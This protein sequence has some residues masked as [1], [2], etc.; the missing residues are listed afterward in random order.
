MKLIAVFMLVTMLAACAGPRPAAP[1]AATVIAPP[2]WRQGME[3]GGEI[4][5]R[6]WEDF[7][8]PTLSA[9]VEKACA[10][11]IDIALAAARVEEAH[12]QFNAAR[13]QRLPHADLL[14]A[15]RRE[16]FLGAMGRHESQTAAQSEIGLTYDLDLFG[17]LRH[18]SESARARLLAT[19][20]AQDN[21]TLAVASFVAAGYIGLRALDARLDIVR[22]TLIARA[23]SLKIAQR[24]AQ[25]GYATQLEL[26]QAEAEFHAT[27]QL[28]PALQFAITRQENGLSVLLGESPRE[29]A[30]GAP[31]SALTPPVVPTI[32]PSEL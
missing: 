10:N 24:R 15:G 4:T 30:R 16:R 2:T 14:I 8:D 28:I 5:A 20:A 9:L 17:R 6:W 25:S 23:D 12:A 27:E 29:I 18:A 19:D 1:P 32:L 11:N 3:E 13:S 22:A 21:V 7:G 31:L 26:R